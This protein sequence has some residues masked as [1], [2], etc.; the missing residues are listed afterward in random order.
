MRIK[1]L[2]FLGI[3][4]IALVAGEHSVKFV[5]DTDVE[6]TLKL[7]THEICKLDRDVYFRTYGNLTA[8]D[9]SKE[10]YAELG[11][12]PGRGTL[13]FVSDETRFEQAVDSAAKQYG[14]AKKTF[15]ARVNATCCSGFSQDMLEP[16][17]NSETASAQ[18]DPTMKVAHSNVVHPDK[19]KAAANLV[20]KWVEEVYA[21]GAY[22]PDYISTMN[23]PD[24]SWSGAA[25]PVEDFTN[26][27]IVMAQI[28][29]NKAGGVKIAGP[30]TA[31][32]YQG[33]N[34]ARWKN[35]GW[36][37]YFI[38]NA[39]NI[40]G[41]YDFHIYSK[42]YYHY[43]PESKGYRPELSQD[44]P[45]L[46]D[47]RRSGNGSVWDF[48]RLEA[49]LDLVTAHHLSTW[50]GDMKPIII[51]E[52]GRQGINPQLGPW[53][54]NFKHWL[55][56][57]TVARL[58]MTFMEFPQIKLTVPFILP[59]SDA[60]YAP[61]RGQAIF[62]QS[63]EGKTVRTPFYEFY[64]MFKDVNGARV[65]CRA[66]S[67]DTDILDTSFARA[68]LNGDKLYVIANNGKSS[69]LNFSFE[70]KGA[71]AVKSVKILSVKWE[72]SIPERMDF[73]PKG[74]LKFEEQSLT[75]LPK[76]SLL[77]AADETAVL[78]FEFDSAPVVKARI[79]EEIYYAK[80]T[81]TEFRENMPAEL[82]FNLP[83]A[84]T[85]QA[86]LGLGLAAIKGFK[87]SIAVFKD[88]KKIASAN[89]DHTNGIADYHAVTRINLPLS[90][91]SKGKNRLSVKLSN[92][93]AK[94]FQYLTSAK[95]ILEN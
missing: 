21:K 60:N 49:F 1:L 67:A 77:M 35:N 9:L 6:Q 66:V 95:L 12:L 19:Y 69:A 81:F 43:V 7:G 88:G 61:S 80:E 50:G 54:N 87:G 15:G 86:I 70:L 57:S 58:W 41:A 46:D 45:F 37:R 68:F 47:S 63:A 89:L 74:A 4:P 27:S 72:G 31:W 91:L 65:P 2:L 13:R 33:G 25:N 73:A 40:A 42:G 16:S 51:S 83:N 36:E 90:A 29:N 34:W 39:G 11:V 92:C 32:G 18:V 93:D 64:T 94:A 84:S 85:K 44:S 14:G 8:T 20:L 24:A 53:E 56:M 62:T 75:T 55:Y 28:V 5:I 48:G 59:K 26:Y 23:E 10:L 82:T 52:F 78:C 38:E 17:A 71:P 79:T 30:C 3:L 76:N 22:A